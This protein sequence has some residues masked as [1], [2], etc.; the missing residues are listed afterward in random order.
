MHCPGNFFYEEGYIG[1]TV[2]ISR[3]PQHLQIH[4]DCCEFGKSKQ[5]KIWNLQNKT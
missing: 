5:F 3:H 1:R 2:F 4:A